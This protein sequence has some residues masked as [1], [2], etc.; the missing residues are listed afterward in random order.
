MSI[1]LAKPIGV[2]KMKDQGD[3]DDKIIAVHAN[4]PEYTEIDSLDD[5]APH[6]MK[7]VERF[8]KDYKTLENKRI[9]IDKFLDKKEAHK[10]IK[11]AFALYAKN[12]KKLR[13]S[14]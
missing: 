9:A 8:F 13:Q 12:E 7:E 3:P 14:K 2:M 4:D 10:V 5:L 6:R 11:D 1:M